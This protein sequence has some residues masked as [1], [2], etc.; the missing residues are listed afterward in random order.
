MNDYNDFG[1]WCHADCLK[2]SACTSIHLCA[3]PNLFC[4]LTQ[5]FLCTTSQWVTITCIMS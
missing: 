5:L 4:M 3:M 1:G 2:Q